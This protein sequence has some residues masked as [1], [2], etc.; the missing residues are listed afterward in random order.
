MGIPI[1]T[2]DL[3]G[4]FANNMKRAE[5][6]RR[7]LGAFGR[8]T[9]VGDEDMETQLSD[10]LCDLRH[11]AD[12]EKV[13]WSEVLRRASFHYSAETSCTCPS[14]RAKGDAMDYEFDVRKEGDFAICYKCG[15]SFKIKS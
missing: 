1:V 4:S 12:E 15:E 9:G 6:A 8:E 5:W 7:A 3:M 2:R 14:C 10:L 11:L 13:E